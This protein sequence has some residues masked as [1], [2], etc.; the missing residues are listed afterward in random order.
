MKLEEKQKP[1]PA[2]KAKEMA[3]PLPLWSLKDRSLEREF[4]LDG[5]RAAVNFVNKVADVA[6]RL[7][8]HPDINIRYNKVQLV[9]STHKA[10]GLTDEDF[11]LA[12]EIDKLAV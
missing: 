2:Q 4:T 3:R 6:E 12:A 10:G 1:I 8:H 5:F 9:L 7:D 11:A